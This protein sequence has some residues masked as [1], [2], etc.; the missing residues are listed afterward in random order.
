M[1]A[2]P[3]P[4]QRPAIILHVRDNVATALMHLEPGRALRLTRGPQPVEVTVREPIPLGHKM[5]IRA[6]PAGSDVI[7]YGESI[8]TATAEVGAGCHA[9]VHNMKSRRT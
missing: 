1:S 6:I 7:K 4:P 2:D 9:H 3:E 8:G 5:A